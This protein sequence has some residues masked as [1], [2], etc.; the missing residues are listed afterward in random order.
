MALAVKYFGNSNKLDDKNVVLEVRPKKVYEEI[1]NLSD[2]GTLFQ[3]IAIQG[4]GTIGF[5]IKIQYSIN[6]YGNLS[7]QKENSDPEKKEGDPDTV[8]EDV[9]FDYKEEI[10]FTKNKPEI[11]VLEDVPYCRYLKYTV[12][13][14]ICTLFS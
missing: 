9:W 12:Y 1:Y 7:T 11:K 5:K 14:S 2:T 4:S 10:S 8:I 3:K 13:I 6:P